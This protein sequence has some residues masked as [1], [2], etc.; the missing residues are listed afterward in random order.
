MNAI[1]STRY[2]CTSLTAVVPRNAFVLWLQLMQRDIT[3]GNNIWGLTLKLNC[4]I[5]SSRVI[6]YRYEKNIKVII[7]PSI[8]STP[9]QNILYPKRI[10]WMYNS[11]GGFQS[12]RITVEEVALHL[13]SL[14]G[15]LGAENIEWYLK[16]HIFWIKSQMHY[17]F[18]IVHNILHSSWQW[19]FHMSLNILDEYKDGIF[20]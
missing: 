3:N 16:N 15:A 12:T 20:C 7:L 2:L 11:C 8:P 19:L 6:F 17:Y 4:L 5:Y 14:G 10:P 18:H 1:Q 13:V 9:E